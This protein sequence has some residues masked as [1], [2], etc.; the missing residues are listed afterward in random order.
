MRNS[1]AQFICAIHMRNLYAQIIHSHHT[2]TS[3]AHFIH[4]HHTSKH[5]PK[6]FAQDIRPRHTPKTYAQIIRPNHIPKLY[7]QIIS[8]VVLWGYRIQNSHREMVRIK[9]VCIY[10]NKSSIKGNCYG[11]IHT[12]VRIC[13]GPLGQT[14]NELKVRVSEVV[15]RFLSPLVFLAHFVL[16]KEC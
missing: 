6:T 13:K 12:W 2:L 10:N 9:K 7:A 14:W 1:Y 11:L 16:L 4:P 3:Y 15:T 5:M 8:T